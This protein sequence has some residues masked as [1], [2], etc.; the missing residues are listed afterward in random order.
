MI[1]KAVVYTHPHSTGCS[2][3][4]PRSAVVY[5]HI[6]GRIHAVDYQQAA[7]IPNDYGV[8]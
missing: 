4:S 8:D 2:S 6:D 7:N 3:I 1:A 5:Y